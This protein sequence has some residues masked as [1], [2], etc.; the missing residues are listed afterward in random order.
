MIHIWKE[1]FAF[2][3]NIKYDSEYSESLNGSVWK[4]I[5]RECMNKPCEQ[6]YRMDNITNNVKILSNG[7]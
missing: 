5:R 2:F 1:P 7:Q 3:A 6:L 4:Q